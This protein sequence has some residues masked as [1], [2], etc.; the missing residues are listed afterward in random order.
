MQDLKLRPQSFGGSLISAIARL[1][2]DNS[3]LQGTRNFLV[4]THRLN[5]KIYRLVW[6]F[7][8]GSSCISLWHFRLL[9]FRMISHSPKNGYSFEIVSLGRASIQ[10]KIPDR[11]CGFLKSPGLNLKHRGLWTEKA[12]CRL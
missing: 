2:T 12:T 5:C 3:K 11:Q 9:A 10:M 1:K 7:Q 8:I 6:G 4:E